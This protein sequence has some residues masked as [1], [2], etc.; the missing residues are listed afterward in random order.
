MERE[1]GSQIKKCN[2]L[3]LSHSLAF[4]LSLL[5]NVVRDTE[6]QSVIRESKGMA[7]SLE[8]FRGCPRERPADAV[9]REGDWIESFAR[10]LAPE[11]LLGTCK[12]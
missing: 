8:G 12:K 3:Q 2:H 11:S 7:H 4:S 10:L 5:P 1:E 6:D 9:N